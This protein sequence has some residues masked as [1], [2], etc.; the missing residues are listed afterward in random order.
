MTKLKDV[1][2]NS[3]YAAVHHAAES[4]VN[5]RNPVQY[6]FDRLRT[7]TT[8]TQKVILLIAYTAIFQGAKVAFPEE[9]HEIECRSLAALTEDCETN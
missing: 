2:K 1:A 5:N 9:F 7:E 4:S 8:K 3:Y 6:A